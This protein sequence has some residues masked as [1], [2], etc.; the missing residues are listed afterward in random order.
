MP[1]SGPLIS[2]AATLPAAE[3]SRV[4][5]YPAFYAWFGKQ[6]RGADLEEREKPF[7]FRA[8]DELLPRKVFPSLPHESRAWM[9]PFQL[10]PPSL[11][12]I[13]PTFP[14]NSG[15]KV[16]CARLR[17][18]SSSGE[19]IPSRIV[20]G[21]SSRTLDRGGCRFFES[22]FEIGK[23]KLCFFFLLINGKN[24]VR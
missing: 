9:V 14:R 5:N 4:D 8:L 15:G 12:T 2:S 16:R 23:K 24:F 21:N 3:P 18:F 22:F 19:P 10:S 17:R 1:R 20:E 6:P 7:L 13:P 11:P